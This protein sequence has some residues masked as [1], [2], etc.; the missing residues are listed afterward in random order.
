V[1]ALLLQHNARTLS[2]AR[3][4]LVCALSLGAL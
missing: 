4:L 3:S 1:I 2:V